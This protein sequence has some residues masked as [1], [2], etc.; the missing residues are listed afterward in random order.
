VASVKF[1][2]ICASVRSVIF[3]GMSETIAMNLRQDYYTS[4]INKDIGF[5]DANRTGD[6]CKYLQTHRILYDP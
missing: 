6:L 2:G 1:A 4:L 3:N 5:F